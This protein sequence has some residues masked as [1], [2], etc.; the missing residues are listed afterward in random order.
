M[1]H[2]SEGE[3]IVAAPYLNGAWNSF[4][5]VST[6]SGAIRS[7]D[8]ATQEFSV[9]VL[10]GEGNYSVDGLARTFHRGSILTIALGARLDLYCS[11]DTDMFVTALTVPTLEIKEKYD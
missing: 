2:L 11:T 1:G 9:F 10:S 8:A 7:F 6:A 5:R 3:R 4:A